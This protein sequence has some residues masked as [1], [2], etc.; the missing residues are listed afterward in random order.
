MLKKFF[1]KVLKSQYDVILIPYVDVLNKNDRM[2]SLETL[3]RMV[4]WFIDKQNSMFGE[5][6]YPESFDTTLKNVSH[7]IIK[8]WIEN[9][10]LHGTIKVL[11]TKNGKFVK[12]NINDLVFRPRSIGTVNEDKYIIIT[13][14][15]TYDAIQKS[16]DAFLI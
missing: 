6:G 14:V 12:N 1:K 10:Q 2:Y 15:F 11:N 9:N 5:L 13:K 16:T 8:V 4:E 3:E 7:E